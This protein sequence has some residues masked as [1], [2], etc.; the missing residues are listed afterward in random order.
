MI[1]PVS[2]SRPFQ[3]PLATLCYRLEHTMRKDSLQTHPLAVALIPIV[4]WLTDVV[5][6]WRFAD[7]L[8]LWRRAAPVMDD[9]DSRP[10]PVPSTS[11][12]GVSRP[13]PG[14]V[15]LPEAPDLVDEELAWRAA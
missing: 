8:W 5:V 6:G 13:C 7:A 10:R 9:G 4:S 12:S 1:E 3:D 2:R 14:H 11:P 15:A